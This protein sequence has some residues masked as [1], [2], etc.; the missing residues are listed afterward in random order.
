MCVPKHRSTRIASNCPRGPITWPWQNSRQ[1]H[2]PNDNPCRLSILSPCFM[3]EPH[4]LPSSLHIPWWC[5]GHP[6]VQVMNENLL[7]SCHCP[8]VLLL[9]I[10]FLCTQMLYHPALDAAE[11]TPLLSLSLLVTYHNQMHVRHALK[12]SS[13]VSLHQQASCSCGLKTQ[14]GW[15][16]AQ[17]FFHR[18]SH[19]PQGPHTMP[20]A[21]HAYWFSKSSQVEC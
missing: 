16:S 4:Q 13:H 12:I 2:H 1:A 17:S 7:S 15:V 11:I 14:S 10:L 18:P 5:Q 9:Q 20:S 21:L 3:F 8:P 19:Q 6:H